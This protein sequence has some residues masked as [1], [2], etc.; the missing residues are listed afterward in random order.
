VTQFLGRPLG[1]LE[2]FYDIIGSRVRTDDVDLSGVT[3]V[4]DV[5]DPGN[6]YRSFVQTQN[7]ADEEQLGTIQ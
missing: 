7:V 3:L 2:A 5:G 4:H 1:W 6:D